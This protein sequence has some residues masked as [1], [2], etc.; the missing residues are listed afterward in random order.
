MKRKLTALLMIVLLS[1]FAL[2]PPE[3][4]YPIDGYALT[5]IRRLMHLQKKID[6]EITGSVPI[7]GARKSIYDIR[8]NLLGEKGD[9]L[10]SLPAVDPGLQKAVNAMFPNLDESYAITVLDITPDRPIRYARK[11]ESKG[12]QPGSVGKLAVLLALFE[13]LAILEPESFEKRQALLRNTQVRAGTWSIIDEHTVPFYHPETNEFYSRIVKEHDVFSLYEWTDHMLSVS[14]NAA[15]SIVWREVMLMN[16]FGQD[17]PVSEERATEYFATT[18]KS[19]LA[20]LAVQLVNEPLRALGIGTDEWRLGSFFTRGAKAF[21]PAQGGSI[22][23]P[24]GL[25]K[26]L[27][28]LERGLAVDRESSLEM[29]RMMYMTDRRIRYAAAE[30]LKPAAVYFKSGSLYSCVPE[31]GFECSKYHGNKQNYM[32]S[33]AIV[34]HPDGTNYMVVLMSNVL[35]KNSSGD[36]YGLATQIDRMI[37]K[38]G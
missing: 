22:G 28:A 32:N 37:K 27:I 35:K 26:F 17:Y 24:V 8:L 11:Q 20:T 13:Q 1:G 25:M 19:E 10:A 38:R 14:N 15:A 36:H 4:E 34:E 3:N 16:A 5:G 30:V 23:T 29:K 21:V 9:S 2:I 6:G 7:A 18:K 12:F 33:V 31:E